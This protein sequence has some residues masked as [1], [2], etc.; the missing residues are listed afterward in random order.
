MTN[1]SSHILQDLQFSLLQEH[2]DQVHWADGEP[3][4]TNVSTGGVKKLKSKDFMVADKPSTALSEV[5]W[6]EGPQKIVKVKKELDEGAPDGSLRLSERVLND[7]GGSNEGLKMSIKAEGKRLAEV[8]LSTQSN[9]N[10]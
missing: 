5:G 1:A 4:A 8:S 2:H 7:C 10:F 3:M 9:H 6:E